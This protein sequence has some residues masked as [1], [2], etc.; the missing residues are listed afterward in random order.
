MYWNKVKENFQKIKIFFHEYFYQK[1]NIKIIQQEHPAIEKIS[2]IEILRCYS[3][4]SSSFNATCIIIIHNFLPSDPLN[5]KI[6]YMK[7]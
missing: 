5:I 3:V 4:L 6:V 1:T 2:L 7:H